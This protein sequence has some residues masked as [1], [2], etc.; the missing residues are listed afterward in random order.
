[1]KRIKFDKWESE[2]GKYDLSKY[3]VNIEGW[4]SDIILIPKQ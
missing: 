3:S 4:T 1:M 2:K